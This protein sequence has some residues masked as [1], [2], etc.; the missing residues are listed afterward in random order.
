MP[1]R[2]GQERRRVKTFAVA[3]LLCG[4]LLLVAAAC[5]TPAARTGETQPKRVTLRVDGAAREYLSTASN[6]RELLEEADIQLAEAD[7]VDPPLYVP[8]EAEQEI[9]VVRVSEEIEFIEQ[10]IP[11]ERKTVRNEAMS[12]TDEPL[13]IQVGQPGL[14]ETTVRIVYHDGLEFSRQTTNVTVLQAP[15]D[16][17][18]MIGVGA[19]PGTVTFPG[20]LAFISGGSSVIL[21][22]SSAF[23]QQIDTGGG[24][25]QRVFALSPDGTE[26]LFTRVATDTERFNSLW[27][28]GTGSGDNPR[29]LGVDNVLWAAW[30][31]VA[32]NR[33]Q[34]AYSTGVRTELLPGWE[35][36]NDLW[37]GTLPRSTSERFQ[38]ERLV[39]AYPATYGWWGGNYAWSPSGQFLAYGYA[40]EIGVLELGQDDEAPRRRQLQAFTEYNTRGDWVWLPSLSWSPDSRYLSYTRHADVDPDVAEF[41]MWLAD[42]STGLSN[43]FVAQSGMWSHPYWSPLTPAGDAGMTSAQIAFLRASDPLDSQRS[44]YTL[45]LMDRDGSNARRVYPPPGENSRFPREQASIG[46][47]PDGRQI[48]FVFNDQLRMLHLSSGESRPLTQDDKSASNPTWAPYGAAL[49][50]QTDDE[51]APDAPSDTV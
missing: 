8:L 48:A 4:I 1:P 3:G 50:G 26:L 36:N 6:V 14:Q 2:T 32:V 33:P 12:A 40:D 31:P 5:T 35:A 19:G 45:W 38:P 43:R 37:L 30:N 7:F 28:V 27:V 11:Y 42:V 51:R 16:E 24:L 18:L 23:P 21:R 44:G 25:D 49:N 17:I 39:E 10:T 41:E 9:R 46:W 13:I 34:I 22:G 47:S 15:Q 29:S 20:T